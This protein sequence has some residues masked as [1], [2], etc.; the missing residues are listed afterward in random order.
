MLSV[1]H[2]IAGLWGGLGELGKYQ[3]SPRGLSATSPS[4][5]GVC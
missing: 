5:T 3:G 1:N 4:G 2:L